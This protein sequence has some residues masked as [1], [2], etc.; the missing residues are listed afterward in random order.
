M[1]PFSKDRRGTILSDGGGAMILM[2]D[3]FWNDNI[4]CSRKPKCE[5]TGFGMTC[6]ANHLL[7]PLK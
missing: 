7:S 6:D 3:K 5:I 1:R 2:S 4:N